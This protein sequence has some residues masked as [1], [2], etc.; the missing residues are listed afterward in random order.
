MPH[1]PS[2]LNLIRETD[3]KSIKYKSGTIRTILSYIKKIY[4]HLTI[5]YMIISFAV[6]SSILC[7]PLRKFLIIPFG[8]SMAFHKIVFNFFFFSLCL[9]I[10]NVLYTL[11]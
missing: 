8:L 2:I 9:K 3:T 11:E 7:M 4:F 5:N 10:C 6:D 1:T